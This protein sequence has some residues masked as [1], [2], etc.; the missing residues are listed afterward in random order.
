[1]TEGEVLAALAGVK[2]LGSG[3]DLVAAGRVKAIELGSEAGGRVRVTLEVPAD[4]ARD[5]GA[6]AE[7]ARN[8][9][10]GD[11]QVLLTAHRAAPSV[12]APQRRGQPH[13][14]KRPE[15]YQGDSGV[16]SVLAVSSAKGGVGKSTVAVNLAW[17]LARRGLRVGLLDADV[18]G[19]SVPMLA[20]L[21]GRRAPVVEVEGRKLIQPLESHGVKFV[22][23]G[24]LLKDPGPV[25]WRGPMVQGA[26][27][28]M[29]WDA[30]WGELDVLVVDMPPGT[31]DAQLGLAQ[32]FLPGHPGMRA[33]VVTTPQALALEDARKG[34]EM[35][36]KVSI[37][38]VGTVVNMAG[39][40][41][42]CCG[43][44]T[45]VF[46]GGNA[47]GLGVPVLAEVPL[48]VELREA[49][50]RGEPGAVEVFDALAGVSERSAA[51]P[52]NREQ[53]K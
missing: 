28:R 49:S 3:R 14:P 23:I 21:Q 2:D 47:G 40:A 31:G 18:H 35:F 24:F 16:A 7:A 36:G 44:V 19:P 25:V 39:F 8:A 6:V 48:S 5:Y 37:P 32:D 13:K 33:L 53:R 29:L 41:C 10:G 4:R 52:P 26:I 43:V 17:A 45:D 34:V 1:M 11:A 27:G 22:S 20:G 12:K 51:P 9:I 30:H 38:V 15:G 50:E 46:G 42:P